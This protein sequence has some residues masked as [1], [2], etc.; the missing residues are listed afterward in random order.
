MIDLIKLRHDLH[1]DPEMGLSLP[2]TAQMLAQIL[3]DAGATGY[4]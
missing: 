1:R 4:A 2:R 3:D